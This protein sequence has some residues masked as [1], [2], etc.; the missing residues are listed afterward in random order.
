MKAFLGGID[1][2]GK[3]AYVI[4]QHLPES[5]ESQLLEIL[6]TIAPIPSR[7]L[8]NGEPV[9]PGTIH[10][11]RSSAEV[12]L[13]EGRVRLAPL[14]EK[15]GL[16]SPIDH[17]FDSLAR[18]KAEMGVGVIL[19]GSGTDGTVGLQKIK[20]AGGM[21]LV[22]DPNEAKFPDMPESAIRSGCVDFVGKAAQL[23]TRADHYFDLRN[24]SRDAPDKSD[25]DT[26]KALIR[27]LCLV[28]ARTGNDFRYYKRNSVLRRIERRM[29]LADFSN[30]S[31]YLEYLR[32]NGKE[33]ENLARDILISVTSFFRDPEVWETLENNVIPKLIESKEDGD[34]I[35]VWV[36]GC[37]TGE[38]VY[39]YGILFSEAI[40]RSQKSLI[41]QI[42]GT[43]IDDFSR[44]IART[45]VYPAAIANDVDEA[46]LRAYFDPRSGGQYAVTKSLREKVVFARQNILSDPPFSRMDLVSC[47]NLLIYLDSNMQK[48]VIDLIHFA[49]TEGGIAVLGSA[50]N[51]GHTKDLFKPIDPDKRIYER[52]GDKAVYP[53]HAGDPLR[54]ARQ[55]TVTVTPPPK[56][57]RPRSRSIEE[58]TRGLIMEHFDAASALV[59]ENLN[60]R[61]LSGRTERYLRHPEGA[62]SNDLSVLVNPSL[63]HKIRNFAKQALTEK[64]ALSFIDQLSGTEVEEAKITLRPVPLDDGEEGLFVVFEALP[65]PGRA[66]GKSAENGSAPVDTVGN[67]DWIDTM[68][69]DLREA[70][71]DQRA[72]VEDLAS[73]NEELKS[74]NEEVMSMNEEL[75]SSNEELETS[76]EEFQSLN[77][78]LSSVNRELSSKVD[79]LESAYNDMDNLLASTDIATIFLD[80]DLRIKFFTASC[81]RLF[82]LIPSDTGRPISDLSAKFDGDNMAELCHGVLSDLEHRED[83]IQTADKA[84]YLRRLMPYRTKEKRI[85]GVVVTFS[86]VSR[87]KHAEL[88]LKTANEAK[89]RFLSSMSHDIR[90]P[91][92]A[93]MGLAD[94]LN[95]IADEDH[96]EIGDEI[97]NSCR[98][99]IGTLDSVLSLAH[100]QGSRQELTL[101]PLELGEML[102]QIRDTFDPK[103]RQNDGEARVRL[104]MEETGLHVMAERGALLRVLSNLL[105]NALKFSPG[106][107]VTLRANRE[108]DQVKIQ[109]ED[110]GPGIPE[111]FIQDIFKPFTRRESDKDSSLPGSGL[112]LSISEEL[113]RLMK[114][115]IEVESEIAKGTTMTVRLPLSQGPHPDRTGNS[116]TQSTRMMSETSEKSTPRILICDDHA[117][118]CKVIRLMLRDYDAI[119]VDNVEEL[120]E[121]LPGAGILLLDI[122]LQ[123][124]NRGI[125]IMKSLRSDPD[126]QDLYIIAF[127][128]HALPGQ[129]ESYLEAGFDDYLAKP[130]RQQ[131]LIDT[132]SRGRP[133]QL[134]SA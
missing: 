116:A 19:S 66:T 56:I 35:R 13:Q 47:R 93:I 81:T 61:Y 51:I 121:N 52:I 60:I 16:R 23:P 129:K 44:E 113:V 95:E 53:R 2:E 80:E 84:H 14:S 111:D 1:P 22:Q 29:S 11:L 40:A 36:P 89:S 134:P 73:A 48:R 28:R 122:N 76:K 131:D 104:V 20:A 24:D 79:E 115:S 49:L 106:K 78:E 6:K 70:Q 43:D 92:T 88:E 67:R 127:T 128:A 12:E 27:M 102:S 109:V 96:R 87:L 118:T 41:L 25:A 4:I 10:V 77:D 85:E 72:T 55:G 32:Q 59:E 8:E 3:A 68:D 57:I 45:A 37:A 74:S 46:R 17:F 54:S 90:T 97:R 33:V 34:E 18:E 99:L 83:E 75:Q 114:G 125:E 94:V 9:E 117:S 65:E 133:R 98:H 107:P 69:R 103:S 30:F 21:C 42:Y 130:F 119:V 63:G 64:K 132:I 71:D 108:A 105:G 120:H 82:N 112:G 39:S 91:L 26:E 110:H 100:L 124:K 38:E 126:F 123:G 50:E 101:E 7:P 5:E 31:D 58:T 62:P 86:D 15:Q